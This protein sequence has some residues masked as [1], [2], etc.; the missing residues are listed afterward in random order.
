MTDKT[1]LQLGGRWEENIG[2]SFID[3]G[4]KYSI[5]QALGPDC[6][7]FMSSELV[8]ISKDYS[9]PL[10]TLGVKD[11]DYVVIPGTRV[12]VPM[13][14]NYMG[15]LKSL[16]NKGAKVVINGGSIGMG[17][18]QDN[19]DK[20]SELLEELNPHV[21]ISRDERNYEEFHE[22]STHHL[23]GIDCGFFIGDYFSPLEFEKE[24]ITMTFD[25]GA[26]PDL[27]SLERT[28]GSDD[29]DEVVRLDHLP[30]EHKERNQPVASKKIHNLNRKAHEITTE[31]PLIRKGALV[32]DHPDDYLHVYA[33]TKT[34]YAD[35]V[36]ATVAALSFGNAAQL[37][38][39]SPRAQL[40]D[41]IDAMDI[42]DRPVTPF[43]KIEERKE[44]QISFLRDHL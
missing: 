35:R 42:L 13:L 15:F 9:N 29:V 40:F 16:Q 25:R 38:W 7:F 11:I 20:V 31:P 4:S 33:N 26:E 2:L 39:E 28:R 44:E 12:V 22:Y 32:S 14:E 10:T 27:D 8:Q 36:H 18:T 21:F 1:V 23:N 5:C 43:E 3:L 30:Y 24:F 6:E 41:Q 37:F 34:A 17:Y 19:F